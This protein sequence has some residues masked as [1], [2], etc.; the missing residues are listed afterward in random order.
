MCHLSLVTPLMDL[1]TCC[2]CFRP[3]TK[4]RLLQE[5]PWDRISIT[6]AASF[7][8]RY[9]ACPKLRDEVSYLLFKAGNWKLVFIHT[10]VTPESRAGPSF[11]SPKTFIHLSECQLLALHSSTRK[12]GCSPSNGSDFYGLGPVSMSLLGT[13]ATASSPGYSSEL[14]P[15]TVLS[16]FCLLINFILAHNAMNPVLIHSHRTDEETEVPGKEVHASEKG[17]H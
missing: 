7:P 15:G 8:S 13:S 14:R 1:Y 2:F 3:T 10:V 11:G 17:R 12:P 6:K 5:A 16:T 9:L 4:C